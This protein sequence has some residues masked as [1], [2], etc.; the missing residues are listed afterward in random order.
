MGATPLSFQCIFKKA[1]ALVD[2]FSYIITITLIKC[3]HSASSMHSIILWL[4]AMESVLRYVFLDPNNCN[5]SVLNLTALFELRHLMLCRLGLPLSLVRTPKGGTHIII[6][7]FIFYYCLEKQWMLRLMFAL[8]F[9]DFC[10]LTFY[11]V[12]ICSNF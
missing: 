6:S 4:S 2:T 12:Q 5:C 1:Y 3:Q 8:H 7:V 9:I 10:L 11:E